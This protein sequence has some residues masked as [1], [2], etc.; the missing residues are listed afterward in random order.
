MKNIMGVF[1]FL[2]AGSA[3]ASLIELDWS[4]TAASFTGSFS[5][6]SG[7]A[8]TTTFTV[9][10]GGSSA[11]SQSWT[12]DD[13]VSYRMEGISG[14]WFESTFIDTL[15]SSGQFSTDALGNVITAGNWFGGYSS[16]LITT[17]WSGVIQG[18]WWNNG[19]NEVVCTDDID[20]VLVVNVLGNVT[21]SSW[22]APSASSISVTAPTS[23]VM[24]G[25]GL[26]GVSF[27]RKKK[28]S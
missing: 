13:F 20:C 15:S 3:N 18:G 12:E 9:D 7:E 27:S 23:L 22:S 26:I 8:I 25:L 24:L 19:N 5:G 2:L 10:N 6:V 17:S 11:L 28:N 21:G 14:W 16:A 4:S 1:A